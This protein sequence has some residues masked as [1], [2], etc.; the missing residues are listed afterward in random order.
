MNASHL[1]DSQIYIRQ[2]LIHNFLSTVI[3]GAS[4]QY[5][6][7]PIRHLRSHS[8]TLPEDNELV[9]AVSSL[10]LVK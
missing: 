6:V 8:K 1:N 7:V 2:L 10:G 9:E 5:S 3:N 4:L